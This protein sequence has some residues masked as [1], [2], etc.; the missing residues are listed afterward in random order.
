MSEEIRFPD[1][2]GKDAS[3]LLEKKLWLFDMDGTIYE[4]NRIFEGTLPLLSEIRKR[5]GRYVFLTNNSSR[6]LTDYVKKV[7]SMQIDAGPGDF[8]TSVQATV[9]YLKEHHPGALVYCQGTKSLVQGL[10]EEGIRVTEEDLPEVSVV[11]IGYDTELTFE[12]LRRTCEI[13]RRDV[14]YIGTNPDLVCPVEGGFVPDCGSMSIGIK[15]ATGK[16]PYFIGKPEPT[17]VY[18]AM[19]R[20]GASKEETVLIGDRL[21]TDIA[22][23]K[24]AGVTT[25]CVLSGEATEEDIAAFTPKPDLIFKSVLEIYG[26]LRAEKEEKEAFI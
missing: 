19:E 25:I 21:Y 5:G 10:R 23:G 22:S 9:M 15:N 3:A 12:K 6:S 11:V 2:Y 18:T 17:M 14:A 16:E 24:N 4:E 8:F 1:Y 20:F 13:L 7:N 26:L